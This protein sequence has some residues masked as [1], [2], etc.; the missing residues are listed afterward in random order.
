MPI[1]WYNDSYKKKKK[2]ETEK[3][4]PTTLHW[5]RKKKYLVDQ[6]KHI[7]AFCFSL[8]VPPTH[9]LFFFT[10]LLFPLPIPLPT[11]FNSQFFFIWV[12]QL[13]QKSAKKKAHKY[14]NCKKE[15]FL[16]PPFLPPL[17]FL[18]FP[19]IHQFIFITSFN[20]LKPPLWF[21]IQLPP[22]TPQQW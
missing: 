5:N 6:Q 16:P 13:F 8:N 15:C 1:Q 18:Q 21:R 7:N 4:F 12:L 19:F 20:N 9:S 17:L 2:E 14:K 11:P 10:F 3:H 22:P